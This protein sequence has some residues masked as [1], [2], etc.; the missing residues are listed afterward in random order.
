MN[1]VFKKLTLD[2]KDNIGH[3]TALQKDTDGSR[4]EHE[5]RLHRMKALQKQVEVERKAFKETVQK[6]Q[7]DMKDREREEL[8]ERVAR[9][10]ES[11]EHGEDDRKSKTR[12][13][14]AD[15]EV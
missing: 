15:E 2:I 8:I 1:Q 11:L 3:V 13:L 12:G 4:R 6:L 10:K 14:K 9:V 5:E 7:K